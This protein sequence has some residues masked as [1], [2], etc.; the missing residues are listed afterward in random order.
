MIFTNGIMQP[1][2]RTLTIGDTWQSHSLKLSEITQ[3]DT[4][5]INMLLWSAKQP[6]DFSFDIDNIKLQ[7]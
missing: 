1:E 5:Q 3:T 6:G 4:S 2:L 7:P